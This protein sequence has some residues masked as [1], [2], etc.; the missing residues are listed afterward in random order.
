M[1]EF[2]WLD[3]ARYQSVFQLAVALNLGLSVFRQLMEPHERNFRTRL[4]RI[5]NDFVR[6]G[7]AGCR[8]LE[9]SLK[10]PLEKKRK[11]EIFHGMML[12]TKI[13]IEQAARRADRIVSDAVT[14]HERRGVDAVVAML[15]SLGALAFATFLDPFVV[16]NPTPEQLSAL[17]LG[18]S[19]IKGL[20]MVYAFVVYLP[21]FQ[22]VFN[23]LWPVSRFLIM[24]RKLDRARDRLRD[25]I[26]KE[27]LD[28]RS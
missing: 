22:S 6:I 24:L 18:A 8:H 26:V 25:Y 23:W 15:L 9:K 16:R 11:A 4:K 27:L 12:I 20:I 13:G 10:T 2:V 28:T 7:E 1:D 14:S 17:A 3:P 21:L 19:A 5:K